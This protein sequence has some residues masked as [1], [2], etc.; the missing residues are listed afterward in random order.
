MNILRVALI[1]GI[2]F[3]TVALSCMDA[4]AQAL[5]YSDAEILAALDTSYW[6]AISPTGRKHVYVF[7]APWCPVCR[8]MHRSLSTGPTDI[9]F[10]FV[11]AAPK[12]QVDRIKIGRAAYARDRAR[13]DT[14]YANSATPNSAVVNALSTPSEMFAAGFND[15]L[16]TALNPALQA[17]AGGPI[18]FP[19]LI[20]SSKG[21]VRVAVGLLADFAALSVLVDEDKL[22]AEPPP[23]LKAL[24][25]RPPTLTP[26][27]SKVKYARSDGT[28]LY[29]APHRAAPKLGVLK[30]GVGF[31][32]KASTEVDGERWYAFQYVA[33]GS[34]SAFGRLDEFR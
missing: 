5:A 18:G 15:V 24:L 29:A 20:F 4:R 32:A 26:T 21:R 23:G 33:N 13:L 12:S 14:I 19:T 3:V 34:P 6:T 8:D 30:S 28:I 31:M 10:R 2:L 25:A 22:G 11:L 17:R 16:W 27:E 9:E 7:A 1:A